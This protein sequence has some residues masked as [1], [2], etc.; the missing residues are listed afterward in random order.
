MLHLG[1]IYQREALPGQDSLG[2]I[3]V[4]HEGLPGVIA[5]AQGVG[6]CNHRGP[7]LQGHMQANFSD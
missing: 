6:S 1:T 3:Q 4:L 2:Q 5:P 7:R